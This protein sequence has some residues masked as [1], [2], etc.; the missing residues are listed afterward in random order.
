MGG[1]PLDDLMG[2]K[3]KKPLDG[4]KGKGKGKGKDGKGGPP[5]E[6]ETGKESVSSLIHTRK[7][8]KKPAATASDP[9][10]SLAQDPEKKKKKKKKEEE[11]DEDDSLA[12]DPEKKKK[13]KKKEERMRTP[14]RRTL[15]K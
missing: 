5:P 3:K 6:G 13:K 15:R 1:E 14:W 4:G 2:G 11:D 12:Q 8:I 9:E 7:P 10:D